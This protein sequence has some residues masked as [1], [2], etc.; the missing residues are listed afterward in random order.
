LLAGGSVARS[1]L[2]PNSCYA[3]PG[4]LYGRPSF[5]DEKMKSAGFFYWYIAIIL[6]AAAGLVA[7]FGREFLLREAADL[8]IVSD[9]LT[10]AD[11][12]VV[13]VEILK[14]VPQ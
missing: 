2:F 4:S 3:R 8:W 7:W 10:H 1:Q 13:L 14:R 12:I 5:L 9:R 11:A 6:L